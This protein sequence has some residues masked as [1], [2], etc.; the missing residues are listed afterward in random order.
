VGHH[1]GGVSVNGRVQEARAV[2]EHAYLFHRASGVW[3]MFSGG[4][5]SLAT[6]IV[7]SQALGFRGCVHLDTGIGIPE[8]REFVQETCRAQGWPLLVYRAKDYGQDY[9]RLAVEYGFPGPAAHWRMYVRLKERALRAFIRE[10]KTHRRDRI[11]LS[12]GARLTESERRMGH[13]QQVRREGVRV[14][15]NPIDTWTKSECHDLIAAAGI[16]RNPVVELL[17]MSGECLCGSFAKPNELNEIALWYPHVAARIRAIEEKVR[18]AHPRACMW[19]QAPKRER[20]RQPAQRN[21]AGRKVGPLCQQCELQFV[22][23]GAA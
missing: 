3:S 5:D 14:W 17:H 4:D 1:E 13:V 2:L 12:T 19:G 16:P 15:A 18:F 8:T 23:D 7:T 6:A 22:R 21:S 11:V 20:K 10:H 9:E